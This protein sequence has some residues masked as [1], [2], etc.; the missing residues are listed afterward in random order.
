[1]LGLRRNPLGEINKKVERLEDALRGAAKLFASVEGTG[2]QNQGDLLEPH[3]RT[4]HSMRARIK[5]ESAGSRRRTA[6]L[7]VLALK[8]PKDSTQLV[9][10]AHRMQKLRNMQTGKPLGQNPKFADVFKRTYELDR[11]ITRFNRKVFPRRKPIDPEKAPEYAGIRRL[12]DSIRAMDKRVSKKLSLKKLEEWADLMPQID[13]NNPRQVRRLAGVYVHDH[14]SF[15]T[16][17]VC[18]RSDAPGR[19]LVQVEMTDKFPAQFNFAMYDE[20]SEG[21]YDYLVIATLPRW[22]ICWKFSSHMWRP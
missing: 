20:L 7:Q 5:N 2:Q 12:R 4:L 14:V 17:L 3:W 18:Y 9:G 10:S 22:R 11:A 15:Q 21:C 13:F 1:M 6:M 19:P 8:L 16:W